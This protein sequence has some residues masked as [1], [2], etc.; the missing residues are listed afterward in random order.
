MRRRRMSDS[1]LRG[2][3]KTTF[4]AKATLSAEHERTGR[5]IRADS[6]HERVQAWS[7][8]GAEPEAEAEFLDSLSTLIRMTGSDLVCFRGRRFL[9]GYSP[10][11]DEMGPPPASK[12]AEGGRYNKPG[13]PVFYLCESD[14]GIM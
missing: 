5:R 8:A 7:A 9:P 11:T 6:V 4:V 3:A 2:K 12:K 10:Q 14:Q 1:P 13:V